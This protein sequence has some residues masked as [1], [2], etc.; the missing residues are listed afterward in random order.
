MESDVFKIVRHHIEKTRM[1][2]KHEHRAR[3]T[4]NVKQFNEIMVLR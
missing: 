3:S 4:G 1:L 2:V